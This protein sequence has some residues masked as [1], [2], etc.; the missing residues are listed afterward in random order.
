MFNIVVDTEHT[1]KQLLQK[2]D[3]RRRVTIIP[4]NKIQAHTV[5]LRVQQSAVKLVCLCNPIPLYI[6]CF[7]TL[8]VITNLFFLHQ[9]GRENA[10]LALS[11]VEYDEEL[12]VCFCKACK[13]IHLIVTLDC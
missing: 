1:G 3:L 11:L 10:D 13:S 7:I 12:K 4:L 5:P 8:S 6:V 9:V 2:G